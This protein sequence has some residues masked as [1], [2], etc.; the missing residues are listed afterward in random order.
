MLSLSLRAMFELWLHEMETK[1]LARPAEFRTATLK[2]M[3][4]AREYCDAK[5]VYSAMTGLDATQVTIGGCSHLAHDAMYA[6]ATVT[7]DTAR[8]V[9]TLLPV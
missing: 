4:A 8:F 5:K 9:T 7:D 1:V 6:R 2:A 3:K